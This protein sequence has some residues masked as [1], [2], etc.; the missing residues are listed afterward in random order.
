MHFVKLLVCFLCHLVCL[1]CLVLFLVN[2]LNIKGKV[3]FIILFFLFGY[4]CICV[5]NWSYIVTCRD[6][7][8]SSFVFGNILI[9]KDIVYFP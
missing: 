1:V 6:R 2:L 4:L 5:N 7:L 8:I 9:N 3:G